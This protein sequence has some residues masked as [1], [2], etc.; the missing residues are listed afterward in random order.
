MST[1]MYHW[2]LC[3]LPSSIGCH[4]PGSVKR[5]MLPLE[6]LSG[7]TTACLHS[8]GLFPFLFMRRYPWSDGDIVFEK[9][10]PQVPFPSAPDC[11][12]CVYALLGV[13]CSRLSWQIAWSFCTVP[14]SLPTAKVALIEGFPGGQGRN[15]SHHE[16]QQ[17]HHR[18]SRVRVASPIQAWVENLQLEQCKYLRA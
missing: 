4:V 17:Q 2:I 5:K 10:A 7:M 9:A 18:T 13:P 15:V 1:Q 14:L 11:E 16:R 8:P 12:L 3:L 6:N